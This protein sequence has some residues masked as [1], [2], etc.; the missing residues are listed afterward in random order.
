MN[1]PVQL[2]PQV[3]A[4]GVLTGLLTE[5]GGTTT[6][7]P[8][9]FDDPLA[10]APTPSLANADQRLGALVSL[11][12]SSLSPASGAPPPVF[13][14]AQWYAIPDPTTNAA[15][16]FC[17]VAPAGAPD[18]GEVGLGV[19]Y[20][21]TSANVVIEAYGYLPLVDYSTTGADIVA[22]GATTPTQIGVRAL[23]ADGSGFSVDVGHP[24]AVTFTAMDLTGYLYLNPDVY[25]AQPLPKFFE[26][27]FEGLS[28]T[29]QPATYDSLSALL[30]ANVDT[31]MA[32]VVLQASTWLTTFIG[33]S[34]AT[35]RDVLVEAG[36]L[37][38]DGKGSFSLSIANLQG[39]SPLDVVLGLV[40]GA[41]R[42]LSDGD[43]P[44]AAIGLPKGGLYFV[45]RPNA[46]G[47]IDYGIRL[48]MD[49]PLVESTTAGSPC[50]DL[51]L[52]SWLTGEDDSTGWIHR[53]LGGAA[54]DIPAPGISVYFV[55]EGLDPSDVSFVPS[56][57][58]SSV[59][60]N[61]NGAASTPL[62]SVEGVTLGGFEVR[63]YLDE[64]AD[65]RFGAAARLDDLGIPLGP[66]F[67]AATASTQTNP[68]AQN[69]LASGSTSGQGGDQQ[70]V[71][72]TLSVSAAWVDS[73]T[74]AF[75]LYDQSGAPAP[76]VVL[77]VQRSLGPVSLKRLGIGWVDAE[78]ELSLLVDGGVTV[79]VLTVDLT[80]LTVGIPVTTPADFSKYQLDL[81]G[82]GIAFEAGPVELAAAFVKLG[83]DPTAQPPRTYTEYDG[84]VIISAGTFTILAL[85]SY[86]HVG[87]NGD[88]YT[89]L[90]IFGVLDADLG[91]P[92]F[93]YVT[94]IAA[95]FGYNRQL[96]LPA[97]DA[98]TTFPLVAAA[99]DP[100]TLGAT[101]NA[102]GGWQMPDPATAL[103]HIDEFVPPQR[104]EYWLSAGVR[105]TSFDLINS[106]A[107]VVVEFGNEL[108]IALLGLS[109]ISLPPPAAPGAAAPPE[110][111][112]Y[113]ELGIEIKVLPSAGEFTATAV[114]TSNS[115]V[116]DPACKLTG[117]FAFYV[118]FG[119]NPH[120]G[121]FVLTLGGYH[122][123]FTPPPYYP[124]VP[125]LG[126]DWPMASGIEV[127]GD[128]YFA[129]TPS[130]V[131]AGA[132][133]K[134][135]FSSG[136]LH[137]WM[138]AH[139][140]ALVQWSP[141]HYEVSIAIAIGISYRLHLLFISIT[142]NIE[143][144]ADMTIWGPP[145]GGVVH[146][147][148]S[149]I[150]FT[151]G[152]GADPSDAPRPLD[153]TNEDGTGFAQTLLP[154][155]TL[156]QTQPRALAATAAP[157]QPSGVYTVAVNAGLV[158]SFTDGAATVWVV[159]PSDFVFSVMT[160]IPVTEIDL[161]APAPTPATR[162]VAPDPAPDGTPYY[163]CIRPMRATLSSSVLSVT[164]TDDEND[165][166]VI[167]LATAFEYEPVLDGALAGKWGKP[168][169]AGSDP[170]MNALLP[171]RLMGVSSIAPKPPTLGPT[172]ADAL[173]MVVET[174]FDYDTVDAETP[175][176]LP[177]AAGAQPPGPGPVVDPDALATIAA[178][179]MAQSR[180][181]TR[182]DV[183]AALRQYGV[184]PV[185]DGPLT[186][187]AAA[188]GAYLTGNP[189]I[190]Q[191]ATA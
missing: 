122:P 34:P 42:V 134:V 72:P 3:E 76:L 47:T 109:W 191:G 181:A 66:N 158:R 114:L 84:E 108:E 184:D 88:G 12:E 57:A 24:D 188:P 127:S 153:W 135:L 96:I 110:R 23:T 71:N 117:G 169:P 141:L 16:P 73:G 75:Q 79:G 41:L 61:V 59:G 36:F 129:L 49:V 154:H 63:A 133:L 93:F 4:I 173:A 107:L 105:F 8:A 137:A 163:I 35:V 190:Q 140:D 130:C 67:N 48:A 185:T 142:I 177:L 87:D 40:F 17:V 179:L 83:P 157:P 97:Q 132:G 149:V 56:F 150:S 182:G 178:T 54:T 25:T 69:L 156:Q 125:R 180:V 14:N 162:I 10:A 43:Q 146:I 186:Q 166:A 174:T 2:P 86:A 6:F 138:T 175:D 136:D 167:P 98:V 99:S 68:V 118:W 53:S 187:F 33:D 119:D 11:F 78:G 116:L 85:G 145:T 44:Y 18:T 55:R 77:P 102:S 28:G 38:S 176:H 5:S 159:R 15:S 27:A 32:D 37:T 65:W 92:A 160:T 62:F 112:A 128:A 126:F 95:G 45:D 164:V 9:W 100:S 101:K 115:F 80:G 30:D 13:D 81:E 52:G 139:M 144:G 94:G 74:F 29:T 50:V 103:S 168:V 70:P 26:L 46:D 64:H 7:Q 148:L 172:G 124:T 104:G 39:V 113:A 147:N 152:F 120:A 155:A 89:S 82:L 22:A 183:L 170:E 171:G 19:L 131:M 21:T 189:L 90:F 31:W 161:V 121:Q 91:G 123:A 58:L 1:V 151:V 51:T 165:D 20:T 143:L 60:V 111:Y 106:T